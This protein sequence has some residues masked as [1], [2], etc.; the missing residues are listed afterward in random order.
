MTGITG[1]GFLTSPITRPY[2]NTAYVLPD[3][4]YARK[5]LEL[6]ITAVNINAFIANRP[7]RTCSHAFAAGP[8][9]IFDLLIGV[10]AQV[11]QH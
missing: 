10:K 9:I 3:S 7:S 1:C 2:A 11:S 5:F 8:A 4:P 6:R